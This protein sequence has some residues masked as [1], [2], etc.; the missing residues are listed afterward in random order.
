MVIIALG[1]VLLSFNAAAL[2][3]SMSGM[4]ESF[5]TPPTTVGTAIVMH[6]LGVSAF[7][8]LGA[9]L[10][11]R[12]GSRLFFKLRQRSSSLRWSSCRS[13]PPPG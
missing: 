1:Q 12:F 5:Q 7:I 8:L 11:Q 2:P 10:G 4:V 3:V 13:S 9:K 6:A